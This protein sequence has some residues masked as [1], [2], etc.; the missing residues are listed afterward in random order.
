[1]DLEGIGKRLR[2]ERERLQLSQEQLAAIAG[3]NRI[4]PSRY[5]GG[6]HL[7]TIAFLATIEGA[8]VDVGYV[9][10]G[11][12]DVVALGAD[13]AELLGCA[14][15]IVDD[16]L[17]KH[18]LKPSEEVRGLLI[19]KTL[20]DANGSVCEARMRPPSLEKLIADLAK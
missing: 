10:N 20:R 14:V 2:D 3:T 9:L 5:E 7:P 16:H 8:G 17:A 18:L 4:T 13:D 6:T 15:A 12:R 11:K 19:L 1:M